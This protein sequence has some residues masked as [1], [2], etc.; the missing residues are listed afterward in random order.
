MHHVTQPYTAVGVHFACISD[1]HETMHT[2]HSA[3]FTYGVKEWNAYTAVGVHFA[4]ISDAHETMHT[5][6]SALFTYGVKEWN[7]VEVSKLAKLNETGLR[8]PNGVEV[9]KCGGKV[10]RSAR[11]TTFFII[12]NKDSAILPNKMWYIYKN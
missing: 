2:P 9:Q 3:L 7:G 11:C 8:Q 12:I 10:K 5:P 4:C 6:H 1:A